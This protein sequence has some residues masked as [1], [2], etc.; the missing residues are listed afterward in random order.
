M[1]LSR[2]SPLNARTPPVGAIS[3]RDIRADSVLPE[4]FVTRIRGGRSRC[5]PPCARTQALIVLKDAQSLLCSGSCLDDESYFRCYFQLTLGTILI[6][7]SL[8]YE[9]P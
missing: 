1:L 5:S 6:R 8:D 3:K 4:R 9:V 7:G 2:I